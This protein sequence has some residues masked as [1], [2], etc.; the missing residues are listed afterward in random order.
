MQRGSVDL[1]AVV[2]DPR[3]AGT[4]WRDLHISSLFDN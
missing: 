1:D 2:G 3:Q 4:S